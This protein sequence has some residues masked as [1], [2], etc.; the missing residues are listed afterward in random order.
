[1]FRELLL[2]RRSHRH[3]VEHGINRNPSQQLLL[4]KRD[5]QLVVSFTQL[6]IDLI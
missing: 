6:W 2:E 4:F 5:T 1:M 3:A